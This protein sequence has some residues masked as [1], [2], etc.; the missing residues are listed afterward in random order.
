MDRNIQSNRQIGAQFR[1]SGGSELVVSD[2]ERLVLDLVRRHRDG[3]RR[4]ELTKETDLT[5]QSISRI[6]DTLVDRG[7]LRLEKRRAIERQQHGAAVS[8]VSDA[9]YVIGISIMVDS[10]S[11]VLMNFQGE[12]VDQ[13]FSA[14]SPVNRK[15]VLNTIEEH[16]ETL[17]Q[18]NVKDRASVFGV[19]VGITGYFVGE[20]TKI[21][22]PE[23]L[24]ELAQ[25]NLD[26]IISDRVGF[27]VWLDN[28]GNAA[29][30]GEAHSGAGLTYETFAFIYFSQ[31]IGG[32]IVID[33]KV[34]QGAHNNAGEFGGVFHP[35]VFDDRPSLQ[36]LLRLLA[37]NGIELETIHDL[38]E[39]YDPN[40]PGVDEWIERVKPQLE[41]LFSVINAVVDPAAIIL[42]GQLP[43]ALAQRLCGEVGFFNRPMRGIKRPMPHVAA[44]QV[45]GDGTAIGAAFMP[46]KAHFFI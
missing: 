15:T 6:V 38:S 36:L 45:H 16:I 22:P 19:G 10:V 11:A 5:A 33:R 39:K 17:I 43:K 9:V 20:G 13:E 30:L 14:P 27:P 12:I 42:G 37:E 8:L 23:P 29:A 31:G 7:L 34:F 2:N 28:D 25:V 44:S 41:M 40:W 4:A 26:A 1:R 32:S 24:G 35:D 3:I 21:N 18:R 46:F